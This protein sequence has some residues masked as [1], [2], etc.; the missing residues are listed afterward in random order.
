MTLRPI[1]TAVEIS[2]TLSYA[3][4]ALRLI[5]RGQALLMPVFALYCAAMSAYMIWGPSTVRQFIWV[6]PALL[7]LRFAVVMEAL[8]LLM[9]RTNRGF[10]WSIL[11]TMMFAGAALATRVMGFYPITDLAGWYRTVTQVVHIVLATACLGASIYQLLF[12]GDVRW[13]ALWL[14]H[15]RLV[16]AYMMLRGVMSFYYAIPKGGWATYATLR[17]VFLSGVCGW[18]AVWLW[19]DGRE[20]RA[21]RFRRANS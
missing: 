19:Y 18:A 2:A 5:R 6:Q 1:L 10:L 13:N 17:I 3:L 9:D 21:K 14:P 16:S 15:F 7:L 8:G 12:R 11:L 4:L 20:L